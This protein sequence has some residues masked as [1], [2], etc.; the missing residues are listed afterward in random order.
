MNG[1]AIYARLY[2][3]LSASPQPSAWGN[4]AGTV[5]H[6]NLNRRVRKYSVD[7]IKSLTTCTDEKKEKRSNSKT[8]L[9][10]LYIGPSPLFAFKLRLV[11]HMLH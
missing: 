10:R 9:T 8:Y 4:T 1:P 7:L 11:A 2:V 3:L 6:Q 5:M